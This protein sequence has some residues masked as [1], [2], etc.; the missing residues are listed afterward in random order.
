MVYHFWV[1]HHTGFHWMMSDLLDCIV[2]Y[3]HCSSTFGNLRYVVL[4]LFWKTFWLCFVW[5]WCMDLNLLFWKQ[6]KMT[7]LSCMNCGSLFWYLFMFQHTTDEVENLIKKHKAFEKSAAA[8]EER[9]GTLERLTT[10]STDLLLFGG[11]S[12]SWCR[13]LC[14]TEHCITTVTGIY[15]ACEPVIY[16]C[17]N[18][19]VVIYVTK[20]MHL[21]FSTA[22]MI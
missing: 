11:I 12:A 5:R 3:V 18:S 17:V 20:S 9:F 14:M 1:T 8:Q 6:Q 7:C 21:T 22:P 19:V 15:I 4:W 13:C 10:V 2:L 16:S